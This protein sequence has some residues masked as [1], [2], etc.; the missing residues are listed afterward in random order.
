LFITPDKY[1]EL[2]AYSVE[3]GDILISRAGTVGRMCVARPNSSPSIIG[4]NL[5]RVALDH[6]RIVPEYVTAIFTY[7]P[8]RVG[9]LRASSDEGGYSFMKTSTLATLPVPLPPV[10]LQRKYEDLVARHDRMQ[11]RQLDLISESD[12]LFNALVQRAFRG[13]L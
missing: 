6:Q 3:A 1:T 12:V 10:T 8:T 11:S 5:I 4:T 13:Q 7:F 9:G 2:T